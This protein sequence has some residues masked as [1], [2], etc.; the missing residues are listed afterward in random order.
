M[1]AGTTRAWRAWCCWWPG[2][3]STN[4][5]I[6]VGDQYRRSMEMGKPIVTDKRVL[7]TV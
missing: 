4:G 2:A 5:F 1:K 3:S 6:A 7:E